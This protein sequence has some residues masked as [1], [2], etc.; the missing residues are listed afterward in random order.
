MQK[1]SVTLP[2]KTKVLVVAGFLGAGKTTLLKRILSWET[3]LS[4]TVV[5]VNEFGAVGIDGSLLA[6][7]GSDVVELTS[8]CV[9]CSLQADLNQTL[10]KIRERFSPI[11]IIIEATGVADPSAIVDVFQDAQ[12]QSHMAVEKIITVLDADF[13]E[14]RECLGTLFFRQLRDADLILLNKIDTV[15]PGA[16]PLILKE[17]HETAPGAQVIPTIQCGIDP[18]SLWTVGRRKDFGLKPDRFFQ[19]VPPGPGSDR[20]P[21]HQDS[22]DPGSAATPRKEVA[23]E[24]SHFVAFS[25]SNSAALDENCFKRFAEN[26]PWELFRMKGPVRFHDRTMLVNYA[27]GKCGWADWSG[28]EETQLAFVGWDVD[29]KETLGKL[30]RCISS[31]SSSV[32]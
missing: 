14:V 27:G 10:K 25:F 11:R 23:E 8:G 18:E 4:G 29:D 7:A 6:D 30:K 26:L 9:C 24:K 1:S 5:I 13:W 19:I 16:V 31:S 20:R 15:D 17:L 2:P 28:K 32:S 3:D 21:N 22:K 12:L